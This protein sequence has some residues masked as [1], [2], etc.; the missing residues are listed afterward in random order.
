MRGYITDPDA[1]GGLRHADDL[2]EPEPAED[3]L[4]LD[5]RA[6][7]VNRGETFLLT[8][9]PHGRR[10]GPGVAGVVAQAAAD[11]SGPPEGAPAVAIVDEAGWSEQVAV[12]GYRAAKL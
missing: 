4:V 8:P 10:P 11:G 3:E 7:A 2:P 9:R 12:P 1:P 6:Y 5:V